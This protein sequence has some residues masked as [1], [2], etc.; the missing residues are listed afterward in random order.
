[1]NLNK[2]M[3]KLIAFEPNGSPFISIYLNAEANEQGRDEFGIWL[4]KVLSMRRKGF[5]EDSEEIKSFDKDI[6]RILNFAEKEVD[7]AA[8]GIAIFACHGANEFF[9]I[10]Q[11]DVPFPNNRLLVFDRPH[12]FPL[13]RMIDQNP[14]YIAL[15]V[16]TNKADIYIFGGDEIDMDKEL[17]V[18]EIQNFKTNRTEVGG[19]SQARFQRHIENYHLHHAKEVVDEVA[20]LMRRKK[21]EYL[22]L[23]GDEK[24]IMPVLRPQLPEVVEKA[25]AGTLNLSQ[26][27]SE[28]EI[29]QATREVIT[30]GNAT[31]D[32]EKVER[33][34]NAAQAAAEMGVLGVEK[35]LE[36]L[37]NG[38]V[39]EMTISADFDAIKY[40]E[41][42]VKEVLQ[43]YAPG[44]DQSGTDDLP[45]YHEQRQI[46]DE[47]LIRA[48]NSAAKIHFIEDKSLLEEIGGVGAV[49]RFNMNAAASVPVKG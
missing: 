24:V 42:E 33:V 11:L 34:L 16:D 36:A 21:I 8:N 48:M 9:E 43:N 30:T 32:M 31:D 28:D 2:L 41:K 5:K 25:V 20:E 6:E 40:D 26:Y 38:Q 1:M 12:I 46:A 7:A 45:D 23:C 49:L 4:K 39:E 22:I 10:V 13:A 47:L 44:D 27:A 17:K 37:S 18:R 35:T 19:W 3:Q 29:H 15:W 14:P